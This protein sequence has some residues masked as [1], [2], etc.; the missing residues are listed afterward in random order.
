[1]I[2]DISSPIKEFKKIYEKFIGKINFDNILGENR[3]EQPNLV[4]KY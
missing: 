3:K 4:T 2:K 1:M